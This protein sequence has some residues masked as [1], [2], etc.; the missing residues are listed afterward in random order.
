M[1]QIRS[2]V[3][4]A[5]KTE[6]LIQPKVMKPREETKNAPQSFLGSNY[7]LNIPCMINP[8][9]AS[10]LTSVSNLPLSKEAQVIY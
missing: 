10:N 6:E 7:S 5:S 9:I 8:L 3:E 4:I 2:K 1:T